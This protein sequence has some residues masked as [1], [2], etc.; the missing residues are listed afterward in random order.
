M[1]LLVALAAFAILAAACVTAGS[2]PDPSATGFDK[3]PHTDPP[4]VFPTA[5]C[6]D[7]TIPIGQEIPR[8]IDNMAMMSEVVVVGEFKG[9]GKARWDSPDGSR[10]KDRNPLLNPAVIIQPVLI[11]TET[12]VRGDPSRA[13]RAFLPGGTIGCDRVI[14]EGVS[15]P[16]EGAR[17]VFWL[18]RTTDSKGGPIPDLDVLEAW[19]IDANDIVQTPLDGNLSLSDLTSRVAKVPYLHG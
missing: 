19:P 7:E 15:V 17:Y 4:V 12:A 16:T 1:R 2:S 10:P 18:L 14:F 11:K 13:A 5:Q 3:P 9:I 8:T 6:I